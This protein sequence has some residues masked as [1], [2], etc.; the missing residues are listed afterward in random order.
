[1]FGLAPL[2]GQTNIANF[3][4][5]AWKN[6][7]FNH[8]ETWKQEGNSLKGHGLALEGK[9]TLFYERLEINLAS[10]PMVYVSWVNRQNDGAGIEFK[11]TESTDTSWLFE[12]PQHDFPKKIYY[13][14]TGATQMEAIV[15]GHDNKMPREEHF[16]F[17]RE[18][19]FGLI[20]DNRFLPSSRA[21]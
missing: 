11:L 1:M 13:I 3:L 7:T 5:G 18:E 8:I 16:Y 17:I 15:S 10:N 14:R 21:Y 4:S 6:S 2:Y 9:D 20:A 19:H 12:N